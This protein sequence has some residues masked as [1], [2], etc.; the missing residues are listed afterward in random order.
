MSFKDRFK[1]SQALRVALQASWGS[2]S[3]QLKEAL[4]PMR[5]EFLAVRKRQ[6]RAV[7]VGFIVAV[8]LFSL[9]I[10]SEIPAVSESS[11]WYPAIISYFLMLLP[12][13]FYL[14]SRLLR[15]P[16]KIV[17]RYHNTQQEIIF[18][19]IFNLFG[20]YGERIVNP[21]EPEVAPPKPRTLWKRLKESRAQVNYI[22]PRFRPTHEAL[23][24][25]ELITEPRNHTLVT[26]PVR[27][28]YGVNEL[29]F[30]NLHITHVTG[31][32]KSRKVKQIFSGYFVAFDLPVRLTAKTFISTEGD[33]AGF[34]N[35]TFL[36]GL[37][38]HDVQ[39][40]EL[41]WNQFENLLHVM[42][43]NGAEA[44]YILT[45]N[46]MQDL[47]DWWVTKKMNIRISFIDTRM[48]ILFPYRRDMTAS[49]SSLDDDEV[50]QAYVLSIAEPLMH[51]LHLVED[52][53]IRSY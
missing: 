20:L 31:S 7:L 12:L 32:G 10:L 17:S 15:D 38:S 53:N 13:S 11:L 26:D 19:K 1:D 27:I 14:V 29:L 3:N 45:T 42:T 28:S 35:R 36:S 37:T 40:T 16:N 23:N 50:L 47:Y 9:E 18:A 4:A 33:T 52:V 22:E 46:F 8:P 39:V 5:S 6:S 51:V 34:A 48:Y 25:S 41:E 24:L 44:R 43:T 30:S 2:F 21:A 49:R